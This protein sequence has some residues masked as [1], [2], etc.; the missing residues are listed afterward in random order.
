MQISLNIQTFCY[1]LKIRG[2]GA[3]LCV[4][5]FYYFYCYDVLKSKRLCFLLNKN[6]YFN[7]N[8]AGSKMKNH[9]H[10]Y[11]HTLLQRSALCFSSYKN[12]KLKVKL[13]WVGAAKKKWNFCNVCFVRRNFFKDLC[14]IS[15]Y[16]V[17]NTLS[18]YIHFYIWRNITSYTFVAC[19]QN[20]LHC[21][22]NG[23]RL[24]YCISFNTYSILIYIQ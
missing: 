11:T 5:L 2:L 9:L 23:N 20:R 24:P 14:F 19:F 13:W 15:M 12:C 1:N 18:E 22:L 4:W 3:K 21:I 17:L 7:K 10:T 6:I 16:G 8:K